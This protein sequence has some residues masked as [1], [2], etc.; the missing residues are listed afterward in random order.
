MANAEA[1]AAFIKDLN[2]SGWS[3][4]V[5]LA[6][7]ESA[8]YPDGGGPLGERDGEALVIS[9]GHE[10]F[11]VKEWQAHFGQLNASNVRE[12]MVEMVDWLRHEPENQRQTVEEYVLGYQPVGGEVSALERKELAEWNSFSLKA[13][14]LARGR[15]GRL[16][17]SGADWPKGW[18]LRDETMPAIEDLQMRIGDFIT[19]VATFV[20]QRRE[21]GAMLKEERRLS[22]L[23]PTFRM[24]R[25]KEAEAREQDVPEVGV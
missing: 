17:Q 11:K 6:V 21:L 8:L 15:V 18:A 9:P 16:D 12:A 23:K 13:V 22:G 10:P 5:L 19:K 3:R 7:A 20:A 1:V 4:Q 2:Q 14:R 24:E 25:A